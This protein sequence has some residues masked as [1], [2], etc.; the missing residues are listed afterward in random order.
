[1]PNGR[2]TFSIDRQGVLRYKYIEPNPGGFQGTQPELEA[3]QQIE[4]GG[5]L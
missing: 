2:A 3:L 4:G 5:T 1:M